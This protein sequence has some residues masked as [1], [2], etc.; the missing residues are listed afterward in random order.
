MQAIYVFDST[1]YKAFYKQL[2][3][4]KVSSYE[5]YNKFTYLVNDMII[6][7]KVTF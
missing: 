5:Q 1:A 7:Q 4:I 3:Q 6:N 2:S